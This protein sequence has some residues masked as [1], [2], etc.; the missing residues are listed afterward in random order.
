MMKI[1]I[2]DKFFAASSQQLPWSKNPQALKDNIT[3]RKWSH[4]RN[5][6]SME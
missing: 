4:Y 5:R 2:S 3:R 6:I 1:T